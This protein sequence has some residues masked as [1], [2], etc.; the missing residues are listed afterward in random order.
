MK[1]IYNLDVLV[2]SKA[3]KPSSQTEEVPQG[4]K[5]GAKSGL[6]KKQSSKHTSESK[7][8]AF[9]SKTG[10]SEKDTQS[11][12]AKEKSLS[13]PSPSTP[14][15]GE[16]HKEAQ[17]VAGGPTSLRATS[18]EGAHPQLSSSMS[19]F[20]I[21]EPVYSASFI[22]TLSLHQDMMLQQIP[23]LKLILEY[24]LQRIPYLKNRV[25]MKEPKP[26]HLIT[27]LQGANKE[28][29]ADDISLKV[30]LEDLSDILK[31]TRSAFFTPDSPPD[32]PI[33][34]S[35]ESEEEEEV[36]KDKDTK[37]TSH[38]VHLL[39]YQK[40]ELEHVKAK[41]KAE[42]SSM[43][44]K[45][46]Y[47]DIHQL[48]ELLIK[49]LKKHVKDMEIELLGD[50][51]EIPTK[52]E[53]FTSTISS[54]LS[55]VAELK[56]I[57]WELPTEFLNLPNQVSSVQE[58]LKTLDS[59][60]SLLNKVTNT[61]NTFATMVENASGATSMNVPSAGKVTASPTEGEKNT[62]DA[63]INLQKQLIDLLG[64][65]FG[66]IWKDCFHLW[67]ILFCLT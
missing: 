30:K 20:I 58:K 43:K 59:L 52:L 34:V 63:E 7:T 17:Q 60:P 57:Q 54:F 24:L 33:I 49:E 19:A 29:R 40:E 8:E 37:A 62:K 50:L 66:K 32:E 44:A 47:P 18:E 23:Q 11:N 26:T 9:K 61:L 21:I 46:S 22:C 25:W 35:D 12:S 3:P 31:D 56:N 15:V 53:A 65:R 51:K 55:H 28:S 67:L 1:A 39:Q 42:V 27:Y 41:A 45:P 4:K 64:I 36:A 6:R 14:V 48:T 5:P 13:H 2:D 10:Q 16:M 38:D